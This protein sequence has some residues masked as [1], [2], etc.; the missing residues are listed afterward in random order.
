[1]DPA[2]QKRLEQAGWTVGNYGDV[3]NLTPEDR[4]VVEKHLAAARVL[5]RAAAPFTKNRT[6]RVLTHGATLEL[7]ARPPSRKPKKSVSATPS[8]PSPTKRASPWPTSAPVPSGHSPSLLPPSK[9]PSNSRWR[10][11]AVPET[12][13]PM[14]GPDLRAGRA[15]AIR[16]GQ[17]WNPSCARARISANVSRCVWV[18]AWARM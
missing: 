2:K 4:T 16:Q 6:T 7:R 10:N 18:Q 11:R 17:D 15:T 8:K 1:M 14:V 3:F 9:A 13:W 5:E 12:V